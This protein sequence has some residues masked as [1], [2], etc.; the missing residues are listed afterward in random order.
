MEGVVSTSLPNWP[1]DQTGLR[2]FTCC[3]FSLYFP[4]ISLLGDFALRSTL[5]IC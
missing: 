2:H 4:D 3:R 1:V 5:G